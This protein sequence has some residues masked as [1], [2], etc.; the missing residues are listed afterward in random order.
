MSLD[1]ITLQSAERKK[2]NAAILMSKI[3]Q[4]YKNGTKLRKTALIAAFFVLYLLSTIP[5]G[6][7]LYLIK[8]TYE[9][10]IFSKAGFHS[11]K[12]CLEEQID[13]ML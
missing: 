10:N 7:S 11:Y 3:I 9:I 5:I 6:L 8:T 2:T 13:K 1:S 12:K 4:Y